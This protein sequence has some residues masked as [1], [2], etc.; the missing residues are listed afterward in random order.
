MDKKQ[1]MG[2]FT[3]NVLTLLAGAVFL[4]VAYWVAL[5]RFTD[6]AGLLLFVAVALGSLGTVLL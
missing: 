5:Y 3:G 6:I 2:H 4:G 1:D